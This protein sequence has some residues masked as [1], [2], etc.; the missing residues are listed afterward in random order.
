VTYP[1]GEAGRRL[2]GP[3]LSETM[4]VCLFQDQVIDIGIAAGLTPDQSAAL[5]RAMSSARSPERIAAVR[6]PLARRLTACGLDEEGVRQVLGMIQTFASYGFVR[7]HACAFAHLAYISAWLKVF[8]PAIFLAALLDMQPMGF[9]DA[10]TLIQDARRHG[11]RVLPVDVRHSHADCTIE[12]GAVR[13]GV[14]LI[15]GLG[16]DACTRLEETLGTAPFPATLDA[17]CARAHLDEDEARAL[18][19][20][21][22]LRGYIAGRREALWQAPVVARAARERWMPGLRE[23][24]EVPVRLPAPSPR[25]DAALDYAALGLSM[26]G[27]PLALLRRRLPAS[28]KRADDLMMLRNGSVVEIAG[29]V[30]SRQRPPTA[31]GMVFLGLSDEVGLVNVTVPPQ[32][33]ERDRVA[34]RDE[35]LIWI[36]A[37][38]E[39]RARVVALRALRVRPLHDVIDV[40]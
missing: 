28:L 13:L 9:Y 27:H 6:G 34:V 37:V 20:S 35:A 30:I 26:G 19:R 21:G 23:V 7:G 10:D 31:R 11:V 33:D 16:A 15:K 36:K 32:I 2:L 17:L 12:D 40:A 25:D 39:R 22:A 1:G 5:R 4:G 14:R 3:I 24:M 38:V 8:Q 18:A 29:Q